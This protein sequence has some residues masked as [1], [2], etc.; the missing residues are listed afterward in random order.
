ME[1]EATTDAQFSLK[2]AKRKRDD[3]CFALKR[4]KFEAK[5]AHPN[6]NHFICL[7]A[8]DD[9]IPAAFPSLTYLCIRCPEAVYM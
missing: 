9:G 3:S 6:Q 4:K 2:H 8:N 7:G 1:K 5:P